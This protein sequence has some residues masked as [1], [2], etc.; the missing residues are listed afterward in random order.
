MEHMYVA[1][2]KRVHWFSVMLVVLFVGLF[3]PDVRATHI[4]GGDMSMQTV[5]TKPGL[6]RLQLNQYWDETKTSAGNR[7]QLVILLVFRKNNPVLIERDTI[8]L[9]ETLPLTFD[10]AACAALRQLSFT[11]ARYY[12]THQFDPAKY[13]DPGG[14]YIVWERCCR[15]D[16]LTNVNSSVAS[17]LAMTFYLEFPPMLKN[18]ANFKNSSPDFRLP[19]GSYICI[20]KPF[21]FDASATDADGDQLRY[22]LVT[23]LNGYTTRTAPT[24]TDESPRSNYPTI[25]WGAGYS[26]ANIIPGNPPLQINTATGLLTVRASAE[27]LYLFS[28]QCEEYRNGV[29]I[30]AVRRDFQLPVVDCSKNTPPPAVVMTNGAVA[31]DLAWCGSQPLVLS[32]DKNPAWAYQWQKDGDNVRGATADTLTIRETGVYRVVKSLAKTC[33]NDTGSQSVKVTFVTAPPVKLTIARPK[34]YC[35]GDTITLKAEGQPGYQYRW[36]KDGKDVVG[37]QQATLQTDQTGLYSV[38][39]K[40]VLAVCEGQD[41]VR[42][43]INNRPLAQIKPS[44]LSFCP[45]ESVQLTAGNTAGY[46]YQ[47]QQNGIQRKDSTAQ[48]TARLAGTYVVTVTAPTGCTATSTPVVLTQNARP[49]VQL[50]SIAPLCLSTSTIVTLAGLPAGGTYTGF[51][52]SNN[53]FDPKTAGVGRYKITYTVTS[54]RGCQAEQSRWVDIAAGPKLTGQTIYYLVKGKS[55][56]LQTQT[57]QPISQ[58]RWEPPN[59]LDKVDVASPVATPDQTT[60]Y[61]LTA[62]SAAGCVA[63]LA[64]LVEVAEPLYIPSAFSP[65]GDAVN[66]AWVIPNIGSFPACE[67]SIF[68]RWGELIF[69]SKGYAQPWRGLY[70]DVP[71]PPGLYAY[72]IK[73][74]NGPLATTYRG[75]LL[76]VR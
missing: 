24:L 60:P 30:G 43:V 53:Q 46:R 14:Y 63:T 21:T 13:T 20:G 22:S 76:V 51:G 44:S 66:E 48:I 19:N 12:G 25:A 75:Q 3:R 16:A 55:V 73:T 72:Q 57:D 15:N 67:V 11:Q 74:N 7:D 17:G 35:T 65:N 34:P 41:T 49:L 32:V 27:G 58:Y 10:N 1:R 37:Q 33:A 2:E 38:L 28:V 5:G 29:L 4:I 23:P 68:N 56:Q 8:L 52:V 9:Q 6:F 47:W 18:G 64:V 31:T 54:D 69:Y 45:D 36:Q 40:P 26:L 39:A 70:H 59:A 61:A 62:V 50:D 42:V 71:V